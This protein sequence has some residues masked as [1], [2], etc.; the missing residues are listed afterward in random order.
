MFWQKELFIIKD[1]PINPIEDIKK[2]GM[3]I[4]ISDIEVNDN[5]ILFDAFSNNLDKGA[6]GGL[7]QVAELGKVIL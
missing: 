4:I 1:E 3:S 6:A 2:D 5:E 7:I